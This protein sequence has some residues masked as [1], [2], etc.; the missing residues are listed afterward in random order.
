MFVELIGQSW[1]RVVANPSVVAEENTEWASARLRNILHQP[2]GVYVWV[3]VCVSQ[4]LASIC[5]G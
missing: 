1:G 4:V 2:R 5:L 3:R